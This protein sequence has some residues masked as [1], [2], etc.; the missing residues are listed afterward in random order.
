MARH[1][2]IGRG[3]DQ[4]GFSYRISYQPDWLDRI[5]VTRRLPSGRQSTRTLFRNPARKPG[6][7]AGDLVRIR[8][9]SPAQGLVIETSFRTP[10]GAVGEVEV[11]W[12]GNAA[13]AHEGDH[14]RFR[15]TAFPP[16]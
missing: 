13:P 7:D 11:Q 8:I 14:V 6:G 12:R 16:A 4:C 3:V 9:E 1:N 5:R 10:S 15:L 2:R